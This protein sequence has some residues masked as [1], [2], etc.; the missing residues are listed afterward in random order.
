MN[1]YHVGKSTYI[2]HNNKT[3]ELTA[4]ENKEYLALKSREYEIE[5][6]LKTAKKALEAF[7]DKITKFNNNQ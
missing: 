4:D 3:V 6:E 2:T 5:S 7:A 1:Y